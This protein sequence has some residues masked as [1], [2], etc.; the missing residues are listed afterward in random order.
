MAIQITVQLMIDLTKLILKWQN[1]RVVKNKRENWRNGNRKTRL[2]KWKKYK[3]NKG[4]N[5]REKLR[6]KWERRKE[7]V[8]WE[9]SGI[10]ERES[11]K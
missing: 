9:R 1:I 8:R 7:K 11:K 10:R 6:R 3:E 2:N 5:K 4:N